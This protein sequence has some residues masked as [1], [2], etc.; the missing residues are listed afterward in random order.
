MEI[1]LLPTTY[2]P[3]PLIGNISDHHNF[4][5]GMNQ[6]IISMLRLQLQ[7]ETVKVFP[8]NVEGYFNSTNKNH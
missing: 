4:Y 5:K 7:M 8:R 3:L 6:W 2:S 1:L